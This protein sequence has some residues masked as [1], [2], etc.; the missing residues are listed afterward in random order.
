MPRWVVREGP[1]APSQTSSGHTSELRDTTTTKLDL[2]VMDMVRKE[3]SQRKGGC[4]S[5]AAVDQHREGKNKTKTKG[6]NQIQ[7]GEWGLLGNVSLLDKLFIIFIARKQKIS[8]E[9]GTGLD[10]RRARVSGHTGGRS[11][12]FEPWE[13]IRGDSFRNRRIKQQRLVRLHC[14][15]FN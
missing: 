4:G 3:Q 8:R 7:A 15:W 12:T 13:I 11:P 5:A 14:W 2:K 9:R 6:E 10:H 1:A